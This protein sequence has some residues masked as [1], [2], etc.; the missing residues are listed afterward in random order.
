MVGVFPQHE[1]IITS[2][3]E[4]K[5]KETLAEEI[6]ESEDGAS[7][8]VAKVVRKLFFDEKEK[9]YKQY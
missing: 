8:T 6:N 1:D 5:I 2:F 9:I 4:K 7:K 3:I